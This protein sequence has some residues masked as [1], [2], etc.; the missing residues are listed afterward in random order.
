MKVKK[1]D[2][3]FSGKQFWHLN[4]NF[5]SNQVFLVSLDSIQQIIFSVSE[6]FRT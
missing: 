2:W 5:F 4:A 3:L 1:L 6:V